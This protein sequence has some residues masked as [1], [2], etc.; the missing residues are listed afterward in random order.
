M[1][2]VE[3]AVGPLRV[4]LPGARWTAPESW[5]VTLKFFGEVADPRLEGLKASIADAVTGTGAVESRLTQF[6]AFP[7]TRRARVLWVGIEDPMRTLGDLAVRVEAIWP[8]R[9]FRPLHP[10]LTLARLKQPA[11]VTELIEAAADFPLNQ[12]PFLVERAI[13]FRSHLSRSGARYEALDYFPF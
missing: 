12:Q 8:D 6:G 10:H 13:L 4:N 2:S 3:Q 1:Q 9:N 7:S 5:H 11:P